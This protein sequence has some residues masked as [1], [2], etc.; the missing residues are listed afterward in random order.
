M[1]SLLRFRKVTSWAMAGLFSCCLVIP[2]E[3]SLAQTTASPSPPPPT[4]AQPAPSVEPAPPAKLTGRREAHVYALAVS[5]NAQDPSKDKGSA[6]PVTVRVE[7]N[8]TGNPSVG[9]SEEYV[10]STG[11]QWRSSAW[12]AAFNA[13]QALNIPITDVFFVSGEVRSPGTFPLREGTTLRQ[14]ISMAQGITF[15]AAAGRGIIFR[16]NPA[17][18]KREEVKIDIGAVMSGKNEDLPLLANDIIVVPNSRFKSVGTVLLTGF[19]TSA[20][21]L[22][23]Y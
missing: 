11:D 10:S 16:E 21:R 5:L 1:S 3:G 19:G 4:A 7:P 14:A 12:L 6:H 8:T 17:T 13:C 23:A 15:K 18:G 20:A 22:P 9:I 2:I